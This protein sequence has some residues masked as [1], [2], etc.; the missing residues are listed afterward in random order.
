MALPVFNRAPVTILV[1]LA[2]LISHSSSEGSDLSFAKTFYEAQ[3]E[4]G[5]EGEAL[6]DL[7][8]V[9]VQQQREEGVRYSMTSLVDSRS[10]D[11]FDID[12]STGSISARKPLDYEFMDQHYFKVRGRRF[13]P[14]VYNA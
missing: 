9:R 1:V 7:I 12:P 11:L 5:A 14:I 3:V 6:R 2:A 10:Q 4:E 8:A 13:S